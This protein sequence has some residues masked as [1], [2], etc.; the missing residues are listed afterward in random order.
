[1]ESESFL[2]N[3]IHLYRC[4]YQPNN[5]VNQLHNHDFIEIALVIQGKGGHMIDN[6]KYTVNAGELYIINSESF[7]CFYPS[8][9]NNTENLS[10]CF[11]GFYPEFLYGIGFSPDTLVCVR[12]MLL[13][14][15]LYENEEKYA[16]DAVLTEKEQQRFLELFNH[17]FYELQTK[18]DGYLDNVKFQLGMLLIDLTRCYYKFSGSAKTSSRYKIGLINK[19]IEYFNEKYSEKFNLDQ[20]ADSVYL[21]KRQF[22]RIF[23]EVTGMNVVEYLQ[24]VRIEKACQ[25]ISST[26]LKIS[27][28]ASLVGYSDYRHFNNTFQKIMG[29]TASTFSRQ[30]KS[31]NEKTHAQ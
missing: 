15:S 1:M 4:D 6:H 2:P 8:D 31:K 3:S 21:S 7:H 26:N 5:W 11:L 22:S 19:A 18:E 27:E 28:I 30:R 16:L 13:Y 23:K 25:L 17:M 12:D 20:L 29:M 14:K 10:I 24:K 9:A